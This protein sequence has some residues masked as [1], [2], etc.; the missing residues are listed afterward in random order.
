MVAPILLNS[1][2]ATGDTALSSDIVAGD[3]VIAV[4]VGWNGTVGSNVPSCVVT[5]PSLTWTHR[6]RA[7]VNSN[8]DVYACIAH[9]VAGSTVENELVSFNMTNSS[10]HALLVY[11]LPGGSYVQHAS[12]TGDTFT[13]NPTTFTT[14]LGS[15]PS[16]GSG[17]LLA[18]GIAE[19]FDG[20]NTIA[21][22]SG[23]TEL[24]GNED[25]TLADLSYMVA[26]REGS[27]DTACSVQFNNDEYVE[28][29][30]AV[31]FSAVTD[32]NI[33]PSTIAVAVEL[34]TPTIQTTATVEPSTV[35]VAV[36]VPTAA[37]AGDANISPATVAILV[38]IPQAT[39]PASNIN[40]TTILVAVELPT[41]GVDVFTPSTDISPNVVTIPLGIPFP[42]LIFPDQ[43][44]SP[45]TIL[46][47]VDVPQATGGGD[48]TAGPPPKWRIGG[49]P[50]PSSIVRASGER[51][52]TSR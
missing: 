12:A 40:P 36:E 16:V 46:V 34:P 5:S 35:A 8:K 13:S 17:V 21:P 25:G 38:E 11:R 31:E 48:A 4:A 3:M 41:A 50:S 33:T 24:D 26:W 29:M 7:G 44:I 19:A 2:L 30:V 27:T 39:I 18:F 42:T 43:G 14:T 37:P 22:A 45:S 28:V 10:N 47:Q 15:A 51:A 1:F 20:Q 23:W 9:A 49:Y 52:L 6:E 32:T